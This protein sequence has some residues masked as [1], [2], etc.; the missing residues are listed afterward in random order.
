MGFAE[1]VWEFK[2]LHEKAR[3]KALSGDERITYEAARDDL[4]SVVVCFQGLELTPGI[5]R[6]AMRV[7][8]ALPVE[9]EPPDGAVAGLTEDLSVGGF[10]ARVP[11]QFTE[12]DHLAFT[13][14]LPGADPVR[15]RA[16][17][18]KSADGRVAFAFE[19]LEEAAREALELAV[20]DLVLARFKG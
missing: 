12:G 10:A 6:G 15:G 20:F 9:V 18:A 11:G 19:A 8:C 13:L 3:Q 17:V 2:G 16:R 4:A 14:S 5:Q 7:A 1:W